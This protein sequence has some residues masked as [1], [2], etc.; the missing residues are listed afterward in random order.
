MTPTFFI[1]A[2]VLLLVRPGEWSLNSVISSS[3]TFWTKYNK[4]DTFWLFWMIIQY[5]QNCVKS[6]QIPSFFWSVFSR[7]RSEYSLNFRVQREYGKIRTRKNSLFGHFSRSGILNNCSELLQ[8]SGCVSMET[9]RLRTI[10]YKVLKTFL[11]W[12]KFKLNERNIL[13]FSKFT[14]QKRQCLW[15]YQK[16]HYLKTLTLYFAMS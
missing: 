9:Q 6:G 4:F 10:A 11:K 2:V 8:S 1:V 7:T 16:H 12:P 15:S 14:S 5:N 3:W 13:L